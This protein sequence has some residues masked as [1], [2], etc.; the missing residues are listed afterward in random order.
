MQEVI[1]KA[2]ILKGSADAINITDAQTAVV[3][4]SSIASAAIAL[5][6]GIEPVMQQMTTR[7]RNRIAIQS[8]ILGAAALGLKNCLCIAGDHQS[9]G[10]AG[11]LNGHPGAK[12]VYDVD[13]I[14]LCQHTQADAARHEVVAAKRRRQA[15]N[16]LARVGLAGGVRQ[17]RKSG[18]KRLVHEWMV[19]IF[20]KY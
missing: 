17:R 2:M 15:D 3:R 4:L 12:N 6:V 9:F 1:D 16:T 19:S 14:Q 11:R 7:D 18:K 5:G 8:D 10:G 20:M 13:S